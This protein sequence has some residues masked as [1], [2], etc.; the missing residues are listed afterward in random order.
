MKFDISEHP[1][2]RFNALTGDWVLVSPHRTKRPWQGKEEK[3]LS[4]KRV[5]YDPDCYLCPGNN[6][7]GHHSNPKY[8]GTF[9]FVND[10]AALIDNV[11]LDG[12]SS[13]DELLTFEP[14]SGTCRVI[15][16]S[17]RHDLRL[18]TMSQQEIRPVIDLWAEQY[19]ALG[20]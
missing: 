7:A 19:E 15:C 3:H 6:R 4:T 18:A 17:H 16:Y 10:F 14:V 5:A 20:K 12:S 9:V 2:R 13:Q 11:P 1:H 8:Q